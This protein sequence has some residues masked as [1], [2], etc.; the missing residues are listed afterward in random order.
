[1][2]GGQTTPSKHYKIINKSM[3]KYLAEIEIDLTPESIEYVQ[4]VLDNDTKFRSYS[5]KVID[6]V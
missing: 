6:K 4:H 3:S 1:M 2:I 5:I